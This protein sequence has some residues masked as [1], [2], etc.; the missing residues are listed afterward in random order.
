MIPK[1]IRI[2]AVIFLLVAAGAAGGWF[3]WNKFQVVAPALIPSGAVIPPVEQQ[4]ASA[5]WD[6]AC[7][8]KI[9]NDYDAC[10]VG[11]A[12]SR[13][14]PAPCDGVIHPQTRDRC[15]SMVTVKRAKCGGSD[16]R[17]CL[18]TPNESFGQFCLL[19]YFDSL[20]KGKDISFCETFPD[21]EMAAQCHDVFSFLA[22]REIGKDKTKCEQTFFT[23]YF[24][25]ACSHSQEW[26]TRMEA[27]QDGDELTRYQ[28]L[29]YGT[30]DMMADTDGDGYADGTEAGSGY[31]AL[32]PGRWCES[33]E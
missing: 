1:H 8:G 4:G 14:V 32:G 16:I 11:Y 18:T 23:P 22:V 33:A 29:L 12:V 2:I 28:E 31:N 10:L 27:D 26:K 9:G 6:T 7:A 30:D 21:A 5:P 20:V 24:R 13:S 19:S 25:D 15:T 17:E 3:F